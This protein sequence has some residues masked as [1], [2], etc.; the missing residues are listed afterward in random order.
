M[1]VVSYPAQ[2]VDVIFAHVESFFF[3]LFEMCIKGN[4]VN[5]ENSVI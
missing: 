2:F 3:V 5:Q 4:L 1:L